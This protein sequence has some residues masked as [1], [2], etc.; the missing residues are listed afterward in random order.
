MEIDR[1]IPGDRFWLLGKRDVGYP[2]I[3]V[4]RDTKWGVDTK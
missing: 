4:E 2:G 3:D 1:E